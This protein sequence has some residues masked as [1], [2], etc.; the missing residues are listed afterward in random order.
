MSV[1]YI[2]LVN[3]GVSMPDNNTLELKFDPRTIEH[4]G[5]KMYSRLPFALAEL[6]ANGYDAAAESVEIKLYDSEPENKKIVIKDDGDG[7]S[8]E[9]VQNKFLIIGRKRRDEDDG[10]YNSKRRRITG[11][12]GLGKLALFGI[13]K[14]IQIET[15]K[16]GEPNITK[17][18]LNWDDILNETGGIYNPVTEFIPKADVNSQGTKITLSGLTRVSSFDLF[19]IAVSISKL[20]NWP[21]NDFTV[22]ISK[23]DSEPIVLTR[24]MRYDGIDREFE[25]DIQDIISSIDEDYE[26]KG[27]LKGRIISS[28]KPIKQ[29]LRGITLY[30]NG[31]LANI[32]S[33]FGMS[34]AGHTF[35]YMSGWIDAD[36]LDEIS[37]DVISTDRQSLNWDLPEAEELKRYLHKIVKFLVRDWSRKRKEAKQVKTSERSG[38]NIRN[39][40]DSVPEN[41]RAKLQETID[42]ISDRPEIEDEDFSC[43][44]HNMYDLIPPYTYYHYRWLHSDIRDASQDAYKRGDFYEAFTDAMKRYRNA[45]KDKACVGGSM[46]DYAL[47]SHVFSNV[48]SLK[49][50]YCIRPNG[51]P[52]DARTIKN[53]QEGQ[54]FLAMGIVQA[55]RNVVAHEEKKDLKLTNL[56]SEADCLDLLSLLSHLF[57]RLDQSVSSS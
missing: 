16:A 2:L 10:R 11:R 30:V 48:L 41:L 40:V 45:V 6:I 50:D 36:F 18:V 52:F 28:K 8:F 27:E 25:W 9:E 53:I 55:G 31:R 56:F 15:T 47:M 3:Q 38:I 54:K 33:F 12:K 20:F 5:I 21:G 35:S 23:N 14:T 26:Y 17:F 32:P 22:K 49:D 1:W 7:M 34:E 19:D 37:E 46:D 43:V 13:G 42:N 24:A 29:D 51:L 4:L 57:K 39:W 44:V